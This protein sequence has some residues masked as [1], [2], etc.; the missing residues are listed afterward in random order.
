M[1]NLAVHFP[2][3]AALHLKSDPNFELHSAPSVDV[4]V[5]VL[6]FGKVFT[7]PA[8]FDKQVT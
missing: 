7:H 4:Y 1:H 8:P 6:H 5:Y 3:V 2:P